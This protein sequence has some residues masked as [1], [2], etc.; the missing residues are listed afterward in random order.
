M[1]GG[2]PAAILRGGDDDRRSAWL[3]RYRPF[4]LGR[5][6]SAAAWRGWFWLGDLDDAAQEVL[7]RFVEAVLDGRFTYRDDDQLRGYLVRTMFF[8]AMKRKDAAALE[9][10]LSD[11]LPE[12]PDGEDPLER[13]ELAAFA[14]SALDELARADCRQ[15]LYAAVDRLQPDRR[16]V[17]RLT[18]L[19]LA[20]REIAPRLKRTANAVSVL[21]FRAL[22]D[23]RAELE[24][25]DFL[26]DCGQ[27]YLDP[28]AAR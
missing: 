10:P 1:S 16:E 28:G 8:V 6:R 19:G 4:V 3:E 25:T 17:L 26:S 24:A 11:L 22:E 2:D 13:F 23:L 5:L 20:P 12:E 18:L 7:V 15:R 14:D 21:K 27:Y 9:R